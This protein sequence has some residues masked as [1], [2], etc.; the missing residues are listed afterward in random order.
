MKNNRLIVGTLVAGLFFFP[1]A[2]SFKSSTDIGSVYAEEK[3]SAS[4]PP[5]KLKAKLAEIDKKIDETPSAKLYAA[6]ANV[7]A[8]LDENEK[9]IAAINKAI[10]LSPHEGKYHAYRGLLYASSGNKEETIKSIEKA[11]SYGITDPDYIG[12]LA[13]AQAGKADSKNALRNAEEA[14]KL[15]PKNFSALYAR[16]RVRAHLMQHRKA[17]DDFSLAIKQKDHLPEIYMER[18]AEWAKLGKKEKAEADSSLAKNLK[19]KLNK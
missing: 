11:K 12:I 14:L 2:S 19:L 8:F 3:L 15:D 18:A 4:S 1:V 7:L 6:K 5:A 10:Q 17:I 13:L 9:A 16:G